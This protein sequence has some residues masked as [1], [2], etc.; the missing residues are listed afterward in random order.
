MIDYLDYREKAVPYKKI[1][2]INIKLMS[3]PYWTIG[4]ISRYLEID[5][6]DL[7]KVIKTKDLNPDTLIDL[8]R[9]AL[10]KSPLSLKCGEF[11]DHIKHFVHA[12]GKKIWGK[13]FDAEH[14][15]RKH[16]L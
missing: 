16:D 6:N 8:W 10:K 1:G 7:I 4:K 12:Y 14:M 9:R 2:K 15:L 3:P 5:I 13:N 11:R